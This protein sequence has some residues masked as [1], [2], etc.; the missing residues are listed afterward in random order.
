MATVDIEAVIFAVETQLEAL[1][2]ALKTILDEH[3]QVRD[4]SGESLRHLADTDDSLSLNGSFLQKWG[5]AR[6]M[7]GAIIELEIMRDA[8]RVLADI[9]DTHQ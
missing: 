5:G 6:S 2:S 8:L 7:N 3:P 1:N 9:K 4:L